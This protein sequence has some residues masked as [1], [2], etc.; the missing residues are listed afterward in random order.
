MRC[1]FS[2][3][4]FVGVSL[5]CQR[6]AGQSKAISLAYQITH[7]DNATPALSPDGKRMIY[8]SVTEGKEQLFAMDL[9]DSNSIQLTHGPDGH[10]DPA[11][12]PDGQKVALVSDE[13]EFQVIYVMNP[14][15]TEMSRLTDKDSHTIHPNWSPDSKKVI[16]CSSDDLHPPKKNPS[17]IYSVDI[18]TKN[19]VRLISGGINTF[20]SWSPD[21]R[22]IVFRKIIEP[23][24]SEIFVANKDGGEPH[25][26]TNN[27]AFDGWPSWSPDGTKIAFGSNRNSNYQIFIMNADGSNVC[28]L[29]STEGRATEPRWSPD[30]NLV[31]FTN[32]KSVDW[33]RDCEIFAARTHSTE[34]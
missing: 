14:D 2:I 1:S 15:G 33:G 28:L 23:N 13:N 4:V 3:V 5:V 11:W 18:E 8:E 26:L 31:Y 19:I 17:E 9:D 12:S 32:C 30:G 6:V 16:Y 25:N 20:P 21:G 34:P 7:A 24:N 10:E 27:P 29:A 22:H